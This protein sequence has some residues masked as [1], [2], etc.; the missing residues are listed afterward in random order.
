L[1]PVEGDRTYVQ[2]VLNTSKYVD[3]VNFACKTHAVGLFAVGFIDELCPATSV[4]A[5][6][7]SFAGLKEML[8]SPLLGHS[9][10]P[11]YKQ[12]AKEKILKCV[13]REK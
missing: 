12:I 3:S 7:N 9:L 11:E 6:Y 5:A 13:K 4:Y 2:K 1:V 8:T 10:P